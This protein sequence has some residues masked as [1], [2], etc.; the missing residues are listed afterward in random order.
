MT[1]NSPSLRPLERTHSEGFPS[2]RRAARIGPAPYGTRPKVICAPIMLSGFQTHT[3]ALLQ[4]LLCKPHLERLFRGR[5]HPLAQFAP[6][7]GSK[8]EEHMQEADVFVFDYTRSTTNWKALYTDRWIVLVDFGLYQYSFPCRP[9]S[10]TVPHRS[11]AFRRKRPCRRSIGRSGRS[12]S[13][14]RIAARSDLVPAPI[15]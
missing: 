4:D 9:R 8:F 15:S 13:G 3:P 14:Q 6:T 11:G 10:K 7:V 12:R 5:T 1:A 2:Y